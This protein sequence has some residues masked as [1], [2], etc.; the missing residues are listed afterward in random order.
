MPVYASSN[1]GEPESYLA[2]A[3]WKISRLVEL[4][5][6]M[7]QKGDTSFIDLLNQIWV[8][9][10]DESSEMMIQSR[11]I[12]SEDSNYPR[13]ALHIVAENVPVSTHNGS[14]LNQ[15]VGLSTEIEAIDIVPSNCGFTESDIIASQNCKRSGT[16]GLV[17]CLKLKLA[18]KVMHTVNLDVQDR[19]TN[20]Q[21]GV[22]KD[23][24]IIENKVS[25]I[26]MMIL[27]RV[28][29]WLPRIILPEFIIMFQL[30]DMKL[31]LSSEIQINQ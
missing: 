23:L 28:K 6:V 14:I 13:Q 3:L 17:K 15:L 27:M 31:Q 2:D 5:E 24:E 10:I 12:D 19:L 30:K 18:A 22:L 25:I 20:E 4:T 26:Y 29:N 8:G 1:S 16:G 9:H 7:R 11:F 21:S